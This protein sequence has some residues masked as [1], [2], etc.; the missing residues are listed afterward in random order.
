MKNIP[1]AAEIIFFSYAHETFSK[2]DHT[3]GH[4]IA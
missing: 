2:V 4:K 1:K 3:L